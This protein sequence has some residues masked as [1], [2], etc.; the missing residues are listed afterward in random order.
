VVYNYPWEHNILIAT[1]RVRT[2]DVRPGDLRLRPHWWK[3]AETIVVYQVI[4]RNGEAPP[5]EAPR[6]A[7]RRAIAYWSAPNDTRYVL[8]RPGVPTLYSR[9]ENV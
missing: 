2:I 7:N 3:R 4:G 1:G 5:L 6:R 9:P 8:E